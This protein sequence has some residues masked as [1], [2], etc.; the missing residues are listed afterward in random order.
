MVPKE[1]SNT[2]QAVQVA[3]FRDSAL[4]MLSGNAGGFDVSDALERFEE[5]PLSEADK[6]TPDYYEA[7]VAMIVARNKRPRRA[8]K[9]LYRLLQA[10][11]EQDEVHQFK[12]FQKKIQD[13][14]AVGFSL[15]GLH[16]L[17]TLADMDDDVIW[18]DTRK[19]VDTFAELIGDTFLNSGTL[20]GV[21]REKGPIPHDDDVDLAVV[22]DANSSESAAH[23]W[24][25]A[26][27]TLGQQRLVKQP[28]R[29]LG[30]F[31]H[32]STTGI[33]I[34]LFPAWLEDG[35]VFIYPHTF[36]VLSEHQ[37]LPLVQCAVTGL[38]IPRDAEAVLT[39]NYGESW[40]IPDPSFRFPWARANRQFADFRSM[41]S[42]N[43]DEWTA[44]K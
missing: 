10:R 41:L 42:A 19:A 20:L 6:N 18:A 1:I 23:A 9:L 14:A 26:Y 32:Q 44:V 16:F 21:T 7:A 5:L 40:R 17:S 4:A 31:K 39:V 36:G 35:R 28:K 15:E 29:N 33:N 12:S 34:D 38:P 3:H 24:I 2:A 13:A 37:V 27:K 30:V 22:L 43:A 11:L 8:Q 25:E